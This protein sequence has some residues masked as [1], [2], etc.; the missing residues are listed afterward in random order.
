[1]AW[2]TNQVQSSTGRRTA[3]DKVGGSLDRSGHRFGNER[4]GGEQHGGGR[5]ERVTCAAGVRRRNPPRRNHMRPIASIREE[6]TP[7][8]K[9]DADRANRPLVTQPG[10]TVSSAGKFVSGRRTP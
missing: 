1:V 9:G 6:G 3:C 7:R 4:A 8:S 2:C 5:S 10:G